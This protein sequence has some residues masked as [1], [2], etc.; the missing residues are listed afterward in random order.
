MQI[1]ISSEQL[2]DDARR[3]FFVDVILPVPIPKLF[4]YRVPQELN[5][6]VQVGARVIVQFGKRKVLTAIIAKIHEKAPGNY[7][8]KYILELLDEQPMMGAIQL[9]LLQWISNY[10]MCHIGEVL[11][12]ALPSGL[13]ISSQSKIQL[14]PDA[15]LEQS[16]LSQ[17][18]LLLLEVL[19]KSEGAMSYEEAA[20]A[21]GLGNVYHLIKTLIAKDI[22]LVFE[23]VKEKYQPRF[24]KKIRFTRPYA[25]P[26]ALNNLLEELQGKTKQEEVLMALLRHLP[27]QQ[28][29]SVN[30]AGIQKAILQKDPLL[31]NSSL[32]TLIRKGILEEFEEQVSR[33]PELSEGD[34]AQPELAPNQGKAYA[35]ILRFFRDKEGVLLHGVT[36]S[37]KTE[38]Y[39]H[40]IEQVLASGSQV[41]FLLPEIAL[42]TQIVSRL[43]KVF[44]T[45]MGVYHSRF[46]DNERVEVWEGVLSGRFNFVVAVRSGIFLPFDNLG[47][48]IVD[49][50][51]ES[52][53]KQY[54]PA[55]RYNARDV[56][57]V[58]GKLH[59]AKVLLGSATPSIESFYHAQQGKYGLVQIKE[60][61]GSGQLPQVRLADIREARK[62]KQIKD[63]FTE[64]LLQALAQGIK[65]EEQAILFQNRRGYSPYITCNECS[66]I[67]YC[68]NCDVSL[69]YHMRQGVL[70]CHYC[71]QEEKLP[72]SCA[73]CGSSK[74]HTVGLGTEKI[75]DDLHKH[76]PEARIQRMDLDT[77]R[78]K[79]SYQKILQAFEN[80][81]IDIL[82][83]TQMVSKGLDF[84]KVSLVGIFDAD[85]MLNFP[86]F[87][88]HER[89]FQILTQVSGRAGRKDHKGLVL[90]QTNNVEQAILKKVI[91]NDYEG[92]YFNEIEERASFFYPPFTRIIRLT[93]K[94]LSRELSEKA[95]EIL[96][97]KLAA[98]LGKSR[99]LGPEAAIIHRIRNQYLYNILIKIEREG[100][101]LAAVKDF[102]QSQIEDVNSEREFRKLRIV[103]DVD[104]V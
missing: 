73:A 62:N 59:Q 88:A 56:A 101:N 84:D 39:I 100:V 98:K 36:G 103:V 86:D 93:T 65:Q 85:R 31:S 15:D 51:H 32:R 18:E 20:K 10:Y 1:D 5:E 35:Q 33:F 45:R 81:Q 53:Y 57:L 38:I 77:T 99:V 43:R 11:N 104:P 42:T 26:I 2:S 49:E 16:N 64:E 4:T 79:N 71:G 19:K 102:I 87:R 75:E 67:P 94:H 6:E 21:T 7:T 50:E 63:H 89:A 54:D 96:A 14:R 55:P 58:L 27:I 83:G 34:E 28:G 78:Q 74:I 37:G 23:E 44:G 70:R 30:E 61:Y 68:Q 72:K 91:Q 17:N 47:L 3:T 8:A 25:D 40:L 22:L 97:E 66:W 92:F 90:I 13:K 76:L 60:R 69:T 48:I 29:A 80:Q 41:L 95:A 9:S 82:V 24:I 12:V 46:S 52:S